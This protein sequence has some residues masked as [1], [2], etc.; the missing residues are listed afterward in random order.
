MITPTR[1]VIGALAVAVVGLAIALGVALATDDA[2]SDDHAMN[3][4]SGFAGMMSAMAAMD[5]DA[6][7]EYMEEVLGADG[8]KRMQQHFQDHRTGTSMTGMT[9]VDQ[10]MHT[11]MDGMIAEMPADANTILPQ[12][13][14][15]HGTPTTSTTPTP[16]R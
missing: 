14:P 4:G 7:L 11:M 6:M 9:D 5:S 2:Q 15:H 12:A 8:F 13:D 3:Q 16:S 1:A 10:T